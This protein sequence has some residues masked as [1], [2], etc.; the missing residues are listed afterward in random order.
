MR[1][2]VHLA[3]RDCPVPSH[4][5]TIE[6][7]VLLQTMIAEPVLIGGAVVGTGGILVWFAKLGID[8]KANVE[9]LLLRVDDPQ[10]GLVVMVLRNHKDVAGAMG[11][12]SN[13][14][15]DLERRIQRV[16]DRCDL[17]HNEV[18]PNPRDVR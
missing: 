15:V 18:Q 10:T 9:R 2:A 6:T 5:F 13:A 8:L 4:L 14:Q 7:P 16:E 3:V 11:A 17:T 1:C 12:L